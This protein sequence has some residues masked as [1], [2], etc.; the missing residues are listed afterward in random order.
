MVRESE[1]MSS[2]RAGVYLIMPKTLKIV[3]MGLEQ[4]NSISKKNYGPSKQTADTHT[5]ARDR[6]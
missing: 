2:E 5:R 1:S 6:R 3:P 4:L